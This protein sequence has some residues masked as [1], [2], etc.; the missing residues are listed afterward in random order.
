[1]YIN[2]NPLS[3]RPVESEIRTAGLAESGI[4]LGENEY[5]VLGDNPDDSQDSR[6]PSVGNIKKSEILGRIKVK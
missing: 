6:Y 1:M 4:T 2:G 5:F 3:D